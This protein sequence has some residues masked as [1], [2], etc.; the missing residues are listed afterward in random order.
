MFIYT[1]FDEHCEYSDCA[2]VKRVLREDVNRALYV[3]FHFVWTFSD[4]VISERLI[5]C[6]MTGVSCSTASALLRRCLIPH[7]LLLN[8]LI[9]STLRSIFVSFSR[10]FILLYCTYAFLLLIRSRWTGQNVLVFQ[11]TANKQIN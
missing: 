1:K 10:H 6:V 3:S 8:S 11:E 4:S 9:L 5:N 2:P 7:V